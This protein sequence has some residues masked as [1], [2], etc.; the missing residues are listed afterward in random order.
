M[1][2]NGKVLGPFADS[3]MEQ[4]IRSGRV[5]PDSLVRRSES[6]AWTAA[7]D[8]PGLFGNDDGSS[9]VATADVDDIMD[10]VLLGK[11]RQPSNTQRNVPEDAD[12]PFGDV[13][14]KAGTKRCPFCAESIQAVAVKCKHCGEF[15]DGKPRAS[16]KRQTPV[17]MV[18]S[19]VPSKQS[20]SGTATVLS[21]LFPGLGQ[22]YKGQLGSGL[23]GFAFA[24][25]C[26]AAGIAAY[27]ICFIPGLIVHLFL[28]LDAN[29]DE[30]SSTHTAQSSSQSQSGKGGTAAVLSF[31]FP[32]LGQMYKGQIVKG[33]FAFIF[34]V[35][36]YTVG[37]A[38]Y[39]ISLVVGLIVHL[40][41]IVDAYSSEPQ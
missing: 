40:L 36:C 11:R 34:T 25:S 14:N 16:S 28:I 17:R 1:Q 19:S 12:D 27:P 7:G 29:S 37:I 39:G 38:G 8:T 20:K 5:D 3:Q 32:G 9:D 21:F 10:E 15:L 41:L 26:Y 22:M 23:V 30:S 31:L 2:S 4:L 6:D 35:G 24:V 13:E 33:L 18:Q